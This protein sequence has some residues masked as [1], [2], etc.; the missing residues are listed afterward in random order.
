V[1]HSFQL[2]ELRILALTWLSMREASGIIAGTGVRDAGPDLACPGCEPAGILFVTVSHKGSSAE[3]SSPRDVET[4]SFRH[5][6]N[7]ESASSHFMRGLGG[8]VF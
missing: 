2:P 8:R 5:C 4:S 6:E 3:E 1:D 7:E